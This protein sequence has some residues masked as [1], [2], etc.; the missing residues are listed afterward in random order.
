MKR[1]FYFFVILCIFLIS[2]YFLFPRPVSAIGDTTIVQIVGPGQAPGFLP[3][4][5]TIH[6]Y[7]T[8]IFVNKTNTSYALTA[9]DNSFSSPAIASGQ[10]WRTT[11]GSLGAHEYHTTQPAQHMTGE[12]LVVANTVSLLPTPVP[13]IEATALV[14]I[15]AGKH[16]PDTIVLPTQQDLPLQHSTSAKQMNVLL[17][18]LVLGI[19]GG[20]LLLLILLFVTILLLRRHRRR[21]REEEEMD[22]LVEELVPKTIV[23]KALPAPVQQKK[24]RPLLAGLRK[25]RVDDEDLDDDE[26]EV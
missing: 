22:T 13:Q 10:Q 2:I 16:P 8:V 24:R 11:F 19:A 3:T 7:D 9:S 25:R 12:I 20:V 26:D 4:L 1:V 18:P 21:V 14:I 15:K 5:L 6:Q 17:S 23:H